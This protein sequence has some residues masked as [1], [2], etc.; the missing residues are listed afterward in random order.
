[1]DVEAWLNG[2]GLGQ[3]GPAFVANRLDEATL[4][5]LTSI[6]LERLGVDSI[7]STENTVGN[8]KASQ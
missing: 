8:P 6:D 1:M 5:R 2:L 4:P 7:G 3:Y